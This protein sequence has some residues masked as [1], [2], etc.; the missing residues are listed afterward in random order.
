MRAD[1]DA[2]QSQIDQALADA[3]ERWG[4]WEEWT[5]Y[6]YVRHHIDGAHL[7]RVLAARARHRR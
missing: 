1:I 6:G 5:P 7:R 4:V 3:G 2:R